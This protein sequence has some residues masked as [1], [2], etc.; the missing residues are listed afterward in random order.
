VPK[1]VYLFEEPS[2][3]SIKVGEAL[4][5]A[6]VILYGE[7]IV[8]GKRWYLIYGAEDSIGIKFYSSR[9]NRFGWVNEKFVSLNP[10]DE[11]PTATALSIALPLIAFTKMPQLTQ[12]RLSTQPATQ[13]P[14]SVNRPTPS[15][16]ARK[17]TSIV[18]RDLLNS[19]QYL[20][21]RIFFVVSIVVVGLTVVFKISR[22]K[23]WVAVFLYVIKSVLT[24]FTRSVGSVAF[25]IA[26]LSC[27]ICLIGSLGNWPRPW[28]N[29]FPKISWYQA[30][31]IINSMLAIPV[32]GWDKLMGMLKE[33]SLGEQ[34]RVAERTLHSIEFLGGWPGAWIAIVLFNHKKA[35]MSFL[36][37]SVL[38]TS[39]HLL[40]WFF[41]WLVLKN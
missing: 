31:Y 3:Q 12:I 14:P 27:L 25:F 17:Q 36:I 19:P 23:D 1:A 40:L 13:L 30:I 6:A 26:V 8:E 20:Y 37:P 16:D 32:F 4:R 34:W 15:I 28:G 9:Q 29:I 38:I 35:K 21:L 41:V 10:P 11:K 22:I 24:L 7:A 33:S 5:G 2:P 39:F 18:W